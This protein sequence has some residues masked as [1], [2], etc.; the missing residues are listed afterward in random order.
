MAMSLAPLS[1]KFGTVAVIEPDVVKK[2]Y[3]GYWDE[4]EKTGVFM[5]GKIND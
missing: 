4:M 2:S 1:M 5:L 3:P